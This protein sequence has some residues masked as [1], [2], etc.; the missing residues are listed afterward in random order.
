MLKELIEYLISLKK[1]SII[2]DN[3]GREFAFDKITE[4]KP[5]IPQG[6]ETYTLTSVIDYVLKI[7]DEFYNALNSPFLI[8]VKDYKSV[9]LFA[10]ATKKEK[11]RKLIIT[12]QALLPRINFDNFMDSE[13]FIIMAQSMFVQGEGDIAAVMQVAGNIREERVKQSSDDGISQSV[14]AKSGIAKVAEVE[15]PNPVDLSPFRTFAEI[16]QPPSPFVFRMKDGPSMALFEADG[17]AWKNKAIQEI[18]EYLESKLAD[19]AIIIA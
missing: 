14:V 11:E 9:E 10:P 12:A 3:T 17:G 2:Y 13:K 4:L 15:V 16:E 19:K 1:D 6:I 7:P 8:H 5:T 18:K